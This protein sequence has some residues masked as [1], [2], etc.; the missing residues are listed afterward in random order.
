MRRI[1]MW[2]AELLSPLNPKNNLLKIRNIE[3]Q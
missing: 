3:N 1:S 2:L